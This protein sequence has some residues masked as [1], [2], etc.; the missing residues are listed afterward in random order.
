M[1][2]RCTYR[3][4][5]CLTAIISVFYLK[6][7]DAKAQYFEQAI[8]NVYYATDKHELSQESMNEI[9]AKILAIGSFRI[10]E[11]F[12]EGH[13]DS[14]AS[15]EY[16]LVLSARRVENV[17]AFMQIQGV[18][19]RLIKTETFGE[20]NPWSDDK[21]RN[22]R[23]Q[24]T[25]IYELDLNPGDF[26]RNKVI[27]GFSYDANTRK[28]ISSQYV[29]EVNGSNHLRKTS[30]RGFFT[31]TGTGQND[32]ALIFSRDGY[33]NK[34]VV[35]TG[36]EIAMGKDTIKLRVYLQPVTVVE[37]MTFNHIYFFTDTDQFRPESKDD[38]EK[39][40]KVLVDN[41]GVYVEIQGHMNFPA[42][43]KATKMQTT[44]NYNLSHR[45]AKAVYTYLVSNGIS[46]ERLT[47]K[48]LSNFRMLYPI[49]KTRE[50]EDQNKRVEVWILTLNEVAASN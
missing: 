35:L 28:T 37:R 17:R 30:N 19:D 7:P 18:P 29:I 26:L 50:E 4:F 22:R 46:R 45:R 9:R 32:L 27:I 12:L 24:I 41:P 47:Y 2:F 8:L 14:D 13:T 1:Q 49:P 43:R 31:I 25:F 48:G 33:L 5:I 40:K 23:V 34:E 20:S 6:L 15:D 16:N 42:N 3:L 10:R 11:I 39:L 44:Y 36:K 21:S 38:L